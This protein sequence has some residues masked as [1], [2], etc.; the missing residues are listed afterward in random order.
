MMILKLGS[1]ADLAAFQ[2]AEIVKWARFVK[3]AGIEP[4]G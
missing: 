2:K 1:P 4:E 3:E